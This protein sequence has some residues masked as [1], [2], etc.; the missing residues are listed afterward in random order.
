MTPDVN[1]NTTLVSGNGAP[2]GAGATNGVVGNG[3]GNNNDSTVASSNGSS[4]SSATGSVVVTSSAGS[5]SYHRSLK[6]T[7]G[8]KNKGKVEE[9]DDEETM[10]AC[11]S[12]N[13]D[14]AENSDSD[15]EFY[16]SSEGTVSTNSTGSPNV[17]GTNG[18]ASSAVDMVNKMVSGNMIMNNSGLGNGANNAAHF[19]NPH[20][21]SHMNIQPHHYHHSFNNSFNGTLVSS[22]SSMSGIHY[23]TSSSK[24]N[25]AT[26]PTESPSSDNIDFGLSDSPKVNRNVHCVKEKLRRYLYNQYDFS[27]LSKCFSLN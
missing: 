19:Y 2:G 4:S 12:I 22:P 1:N 20:H 26:S 15:H 11:Y 13:F 16:G 23:S 24:R 7:A 27:G 17:S 21:L 9:V 3:S 5:S 18:N 8:D 6:V 14:E 25:G 10:N